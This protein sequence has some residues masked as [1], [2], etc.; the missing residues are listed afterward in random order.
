MKSA[1]RRLT[2]LC[3]ISLSL[4]FCL[5]VRLSYAQTPNI[6]SDWIANETTTAGPTGTQTPLSMGNLH[7]GVTAPS[8]Q[9]NTYDDGTF[10]LDLHS[11]RWGSSVLFTRIDPSNNSYGLFQIWDPFRRRYGSLFNTSNSVTTQLNAQGTTFFAGG[12]VA[13]GTTNVGFNQL[14]V[15]GTRWYC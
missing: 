7:D 4:F 8:F 15:E 14:A 3:R 5:I 9:F 13:I 10:H 1:P 6:S 12:P 11:I 2:F